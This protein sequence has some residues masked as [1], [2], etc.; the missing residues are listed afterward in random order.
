MNLLLRACWTLL[1]LATV[2]AA[3][4]QLSLLVD[5][6]AV[7]E[8]RTDIVS[9]HSYAPVD[10]LASGLGATL[11]APMGASTVALTLGGHVVEVEVVGTAGSARREGAVRRNGG[12][13]DDMAAV[14]GDD[15]V[16]AP[17]GP[18]ARAF[19]A[20]VSFLPASAAVVVVTTRP[21]LTAAELRGNAN[22]ETLHL[23]LDGPVAWSRFENAALG[24]TELQLRRARLERAKSLEGDLFRRVDLFPEE[25]GVRIRVDAP[26]AG[27][28]VV[29]LADGSGSE[30]RIRAVADAEDAPAGDAAEH[31]VLVV[32]DPGRGG[33][34][35]EEDSGSVTLSLANAV[36][37]RLEREGI[38][39]ELT[40][41]SGSGPGLGDRAAAGAKADL[42]AAVHAADLQPGDVRIWIL[43]DPPDDG[44]MAAAIRRNAATALA[45]GVEDEVRR[46]ILL[47]LVPDLEVGRRYGRSLAT[48]LFQLG[49]YRAGGVREA[50]LAVLS[51]AAGRGILLEFA[52]SDLRDPR[53]AEV[54]AAAIRSALGGAP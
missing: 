41:T 43:G 44:A 53:L 16:W 49:G 1:A 33:T 36:A 52:P 26:G 40:R 3:L 21:V 51:G 17:V 10:A 7:G 48:S 42:F 39:V 47:G 5:G 31:D 14:Q 22:E 50:P 27:I 20:H 37:T 15:A 29:A 46:E 54:L 6:R 9:G 23:R 11:A 19:G 34:S 12:A 4:A 8:V 38:E 24:L 35:G 32:L 28:D 25:G 30:L 2:P 18:V 45:A 13:V